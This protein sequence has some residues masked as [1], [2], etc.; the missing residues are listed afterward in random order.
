[1]HIREDFPV[2]VFPHFKALELPYKGGNVSM[3]ILLPHK[4]DGLQALEESLTPEKLAEVQERIKPVEIPISLPKFKLEFETG[5]SGPLQA[6]GANQIF[7]A[8]ADFSGMTP[9]RGVSV[10]QVLHKAVIEV[11]EEGSEAAAVTGIVLFGGLSFTADHPFLFTIV[12]KGSK[13][14]MV[15]FMGRVNNF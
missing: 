1:M 9:G 4:R 11:N 2:A 14:N 12:E 7:S 8:G 13:S 10:S 5:L 3:L 15:L 6:L